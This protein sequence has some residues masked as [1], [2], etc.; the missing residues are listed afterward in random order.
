M[1]HCQRY[2]ISAFASSHL[3]IS[4]LANSL[5]A[6]DKSQILKEQYLPVRPFILLSFVRQGSIYVIVLWPPLLSVSLWFWWQIPLTLIQILNG[7]LFIKSL[8][9]HSRPTRRVEFIVRHE[10]RAR[11]IRA[12]IEPNINKAWKGDAI[13]GRINYLLVTSRKHNSE[14]K[15]ASLFDVTTMIMISGKG[16]IERP[17]RLEYGRR[18]TS[19]TNSPRLDSQNIVIPRLL[20]EEQES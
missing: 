5:A 16:V 14:S 3:V 13:K 7:S 10:R 15:W 9:L 2:W 6:H 11:A 19:S 18:L 20:P 1:S 17:F 8:S 4:S 12:K